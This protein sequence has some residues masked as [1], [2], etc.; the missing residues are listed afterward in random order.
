VRVIGVNPG[1]IETDR[2]R[3]RLEAQGKTELGDVGRWLELVKDPPL[4]R[5]GRADEIA[6]MVVFLASSRASFVSGTIVTVDAGRAA[7]NAS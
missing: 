1:Q 3:R 7:R 2:L 4:G 6:D 5:L